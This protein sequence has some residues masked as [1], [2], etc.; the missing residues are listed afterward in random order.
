MLG[1]LVSD[2]S[3]AVSRSF[4]GSGKVSLRRNLARSIAGKLSVSEIQMW[5]EK[6]D[7]SV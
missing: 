3:C 2:L 1:C 6:S 4:V 7:K 5:R